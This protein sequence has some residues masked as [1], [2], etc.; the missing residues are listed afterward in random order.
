MEAHRDEIISSRSYHQEES[1]TTLST[2]LTL[3][4]EL[5][6]LHPPR[7]P[8]A[9]L[10]RFPGHL[11]SPRGCW[12][13]GAPQ[14][15]T[16]ATDL[17][18]APVISAIRSQ[19]CSLSTV[20]E[21]V[22]AGWRGI[23]GGGRASG[24]GRSRVASE[25][26]N[27]R[28]GAGQGAQSQESRTVPAS[29]AR[30]RRGP[31]PQRCVPGAGGAAESPRTQAGLGTQGQPAGGAETTAPRG[32]RDPPGRDRRQGRA[33]AERGLSGGLS[34]LSLWTRKGAFVVCFKIRA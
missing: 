1:A 34:R 32:P 27:R 6:L 23:L 11:L 19:K 9:P 21:L 22:C 2:K 10:P 5:S 28:G 13:A 3:L 26:T 8:G 33:G 18:C 31:A 25:R 29:A 14:N 12:G 16:S 15:I 24:G 30:V 7:T 17:L 4:G 20:L